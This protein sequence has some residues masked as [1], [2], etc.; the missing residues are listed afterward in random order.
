MEKDL[1]KIQEWC[2]KN[3]NTF[4]SWYTE[5][6]FNRDYE[7]EIEW[8]CGLLYGYSRDHILVQHNYF[9]VT[10]AKAVKKALKDLKNICQK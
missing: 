5:L 4:Q 2:D 6:W 8:G 7:D 10:P 3:S 9:S 1:I